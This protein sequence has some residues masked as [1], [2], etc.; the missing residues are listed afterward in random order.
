MLNAYAQF[1]AFSWTDYLPFTVN[2]GKPGEITA[3]GYTWPAQWDERGGGFHVV[4]LDP[5]TLAQV[6]D[7]TFLTNGPSGKDEQHLLCEDL[8][9]WIPL[10]YVAFIASVGDPFGG[11]SN[12]FDDLNCIVQAIQGLGGSAHVVAQL[13]SGKGYAL[14]ARGVRPKV[15]AFEASDVITLPSASSSMKPQLTGVL[16][17]NRQG[18]FEP[19]AADATGDLEFELFEIAYQSPTPWPNSST[20]GE[21]GALCYITQQLGFSGT[22]DVRTLYP[23]TQSFQPDVG[24]LNLVQ[25]PS[26]PICGTHQFTEEDFNAVKKQLQIEFPD[27]LTIRNFFRNE[28]QVPF[29]GSKT[30]TE[31]VELDVIADD[32]TAALRASDRT[33]FVVDILNVV[34]GVLQMASAIIPV[35]GD[36]DGDNEEGGGAGAAVGVIS[37]VITM[38]EGMAQL[39][40][41]GQ[42]ANRISARRDQLKEALLSS[43]KANL[44]A[45][46]RLQELLVSDWEKM[47]TVAAKAKDTQEWEFSDAE[48]EKTVT[49]YNR[50]AKFHFWSALM[51]AIYQRFEIL[52]GV[53]YEAI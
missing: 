39:S 34:E 46:D 7:Y 18:W 4:M 6:L 21:Q 14:A 20:A 43:T 30:I 5:V 15:A 33:E 51:G 19:V 9:H 52:P 10:G 29:T 25:F 11:D 3:A 38:I 41:N 8:R 16:G 31:I 37:S 24:Q 28:L 35:V 23:Y 26:N 48:L 12:N 1:W 47:R 44:A 2:I 40:D 49:A 53:I 50:G 45:F 13:K 36:Q 27:V 42:P 32:I 17:R 22:E